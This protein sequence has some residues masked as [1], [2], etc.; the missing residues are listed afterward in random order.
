MYKKVGDV[1]VKAV[2]DQV[3]A[4]K[5]SRG[6]MDMLDFQQGIRVAFNVVRVARGQLIEWETSDDE[7]EEE[8]A[9]DEGVA[10][11]EEA[12]VDDEGVAPNEEAAV[13]EADNIDDDDD[14]E[15]DDD[16]VVSLWSV[17]N[18]S[19]TEE[20]GC[21]LREPFRTAVE[22]LFAAKLDS[23]TELATKRAAGRPLLRWKLIIEHR[24][25]DVILQRQGLKKS[26]RE[27]SLLHSEKASEFCNRLRLLH[28]RLAEVDRKSPFR[29]TD[30]VE[31]IVETIRGRSA[32]T[33]LCDRVLDQ[34]ACGEAYPLEK[35][36]MLIRIRED[37]T[38]SAATTNS[39][40]SALATSRG[41][42]GPGGSGGGR[43]R[44]YSS[45]VCW[46]CDKAGHRR[47]DCKKRMN[48]EKNAA[49][50]G[51]TSQPPLP[52]QKTAS[53]AAAPAAS[54][55]RFGSSAQ[56]RRV[57]AASLSLHTAAASR[58]PPTPVSDEDV[59]LVVAS[60]SASPEYDAYVN[61]LASFECLSAV[62]DSDDV[63]VSLPSHAV[64]VESGGGVDTV[65][66]TSFMLDT[67]VGGTRV[68]AAVCSE[69]LAARTRRG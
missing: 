15:D 68:A 63:L 65:D 40:L 64:D 29:E 20:H 32:M 28:E 50:G 7:L 16:V 1:F 4:L 67:G 59:D 6:Q 37:R 42:G 25:G 61:R 46:Y 66:V 26:I 8:K 34:F 35:L 22:Q 30:L 13:E 44:T 69:R 11:N 57:L 10:P 41:G 53:H 39:S 9:P 5:S 43:G 18:G 23:T 58:V 56:P 38:T 48:D 52:T 3:P 47:V 19:N 54:G 31:R 17:F 55:G 33:D 12:A 14:D 51:Q 36:L 27:A 60:S 62:M 49:G 24:L 21:C 45:I 2:Y